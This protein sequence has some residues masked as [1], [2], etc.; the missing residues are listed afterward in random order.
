MQPD[1]WKRGDLSRHC[2]A[3]RWRGREHPSARGMSL[4]QFEEML[5]LSVQ[6]RKLRALVANREVEA[7]L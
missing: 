1:A 2:V 7:R 4:E 5:E 3:E 6:R